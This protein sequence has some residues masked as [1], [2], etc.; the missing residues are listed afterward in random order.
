MKYIF[1]K[2]EASH[3]APL[4]INPKIQYYAVKYGNLDVLRYLIDEKKVPIDYKQIKDGLYWAESSD[5]NYK[6][7]V[8]KYLSSRRTGITG[9]FEA[10]KEKISLE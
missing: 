10:F 4:P 9:L 5:P 3:R 1:E 8:L 7:N 2:Y 6:T